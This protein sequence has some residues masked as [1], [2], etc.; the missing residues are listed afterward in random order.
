MATDYSDILLPEEPTA[1]AGVVA[2]STTLPADYSDILLPEGAEVSPVTVDD[3]DSFSSN[4]GRSLNEFQKSF[5]EG[6][7]VIGRLI[8]SKDLE[9]WAK[10][11]EEEQ[12]RDIASYGIPQRTASLTEGLGEVE[13]IDRKSVV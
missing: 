5:Y 13:D 1:P 2:G 3:P 12:E 8:G 10:G 6:T 9:S 11:L 7:G 4:V